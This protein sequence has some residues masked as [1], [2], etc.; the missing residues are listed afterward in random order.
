MLIEECL[1]DL[2]FTKLI[3]KYLKLGC[4]LSLVFL[5]I[6]LILGIKFTFYPDLNPNTYLGLSTGALRFPSYFQDPQKYAQYLSMIGFLFLMNRETKSK[7]DILNIVLFILVILAIFLTGSR[8]AFGG[9]LIG[10]LIILLA[11]KSKTWIIAIFFGLIGYFIITNYSENFSLFNRNED[12]NASLDVRNEIWKK[13]LLIFSLNPL[14][15]IGIGNHHNYIVTH[16]RNEYYLIDKEVV[17]Y[18]TES[19]YLQILIECGLLGFVLIFLLILIPV[20]NALL[21]YLRFKNFNII[22]L[23]APVISWMM[24]FTTVNSLSDNRILVLLITLLC[25]LIV[26]KNSPKAIHV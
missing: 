18:G 4:I 19:G 20:I 12:V 3:I 15:G 1:K 5:L 11:K 16:S 25:L 23:V 13:D 21:T 17:Y 6:Q 14:L 2:S 7:P 8:A 10:L 24:A 26:S 9:M 22:C